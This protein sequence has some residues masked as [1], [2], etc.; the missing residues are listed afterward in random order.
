MPLALGTAAGESPAAVFVH[1]LTLTRQKPG[2]GPGTAK[3]PTKPPPPLHPPPPAHLLGVT[4]GHAGVHAQHLA[5]LR[6]QPHQAADPLG[7]QPKLQKGGQNRRAKGSPAGHSTTGHQGHGFPKG[8][9]CAQPL[10]KSCQVRVREHAAVG[11]AAQKAGQTTCMQ[12]LSNHPA[13][14]RPW[15]AAAAPAQH[16]A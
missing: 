2:A 9:L 13:P 8:A 16:P 11:L 7:G 3:T 5:P 1:P 14:A 12:A 4:A 15:T 6:V 10:A